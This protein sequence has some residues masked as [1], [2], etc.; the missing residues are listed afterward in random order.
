MGTRNHGNLLDEKRKKEG[1][2]EMPTVISA[3]T[4]LKSFRKFAEVDREEELTL[5]VIKSKPRKLRYGVRISH[6]SH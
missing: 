3:K 4:G 5:N 1:I 2:S 6:W